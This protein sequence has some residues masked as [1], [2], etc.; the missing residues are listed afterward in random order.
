MC[1]S[2]PLCRLWG[3]VFANPLGRRALFLKYPGVCRISGPCRTF[4][5]GYLILG[6]LRDGATGQH[7]MM[8]C[9][10]SYHASFLFASDAELSALGG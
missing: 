1:L 8:Y 10:L 3:I 4:S 2:V 5:P 9:S 6:N 7:G